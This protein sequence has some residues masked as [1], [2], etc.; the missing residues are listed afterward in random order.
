VHR[1]VSGAPTAL[2]DQ[3]LAMPDMEGDHAPNYYRSCPVHHSI[4]GKN[5]LPN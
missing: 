5:C 2:E 3:Q 4:E 1:T